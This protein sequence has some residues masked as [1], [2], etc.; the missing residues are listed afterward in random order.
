MVTSFETRRAHPSKHFTSCIAVTAAA[1]AA[2]ATADVMGGVRVWVMLLVR[3]VVLLPYCCYKPSTM[4]FT[5]N[6]IS[7][8]HIMYPVQRTMAVSNAAHDDEFRRFFRSRS[9]GVCF[10]FQNLRLVSW[11]LLPHESEAFAELS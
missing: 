7:R 11:Q 2:V 3:L 10:F 9:W 5:I 1:A 8:G 4:T 6:G